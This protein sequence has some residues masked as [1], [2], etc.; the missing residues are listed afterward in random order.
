MS[1]SPESLYS[2][3][4]PFLLF[5]FNSSSSLCQGPRAESTD[6]DD[7]AQSG[8][9]RG[10]RHGPGDAGLR[11][12]RHFIGQHRLQ[13]AAPDDRL[14]ARDSAGGRTTIP[15]HESEARARKESS[16]RGN[17]QHLQGGIELYSF[18]AS[19]LT[20]IGRRR[21]KEKKRRGGNGC[22]GIR[23]GGGR[24]KRARGKRSGRKRSTRER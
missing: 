23:R 24:R 7:A 20:R 12:V 15:R 1:N 21:K 19:A 11:S 14:D 8:T 18:A 4:F 17:S 6:H 16:R 13:R 3:F 5:L 22:G 2:L 10:K 9:P